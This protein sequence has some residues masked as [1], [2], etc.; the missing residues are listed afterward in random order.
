MKRKRDCGVLMAGVVLAALPHPGLAASAAEKAARELA[1]LTPENV[2]ARVTVKD[3]VLEASA[4]FTSEAVYQER[5]G[6]LGTVPSDS[7]VR[8]FVDKRSG[9]V[10]WQVYVVTNY[11]GSRRFF[12]QANFQTTNGVETVPVTVIDR[13]V[14]TC[15]SAAD[16]V[17][18]EQV[19][20]TLSDELTRALARLYDSRGPLA[21]WRFR[22]KAKSGEDFT[23]G[24]AAAEVAG[25]VKAV[26][27]WR[28]RHTL[29]AGA[30][31]A[32]PAPV[33]PPAA[34]GATPQL[35]VQF[36]ATPYGAAIV[37]V[38]S[39]SRAAT[40]GLA[41]GMIITAVNGK[42]LAGLSLA[43]MRKELTREDHR[44]FSVIGKSDLIVP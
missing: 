38:Q 39:G 34:G 28:A 2:A 23:D 33:K 8:A 6:L 35:G 32:R 44:T 37:S 30:A 13:Q 17:Y 43:D 27:D 22:L 25:I 31:A 26:D 40:A 36:V 19:G 11:I 5:K 20:F 41:P 21:I 3:D 18:T 15:I 24:L 7:F 16:C 12:E 9:A 4:V 29:N 42:V 14:Q 10:S 1:E